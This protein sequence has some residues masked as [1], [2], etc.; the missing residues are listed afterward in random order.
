MNLA[1]AQYALKTRDCSLHEHAAASAY[2]HSYYTFERPDLLRPVRLTYDA[3]PRRIVRDDIEPTRRA[4]NPNESSKVGPRRIMRLD[5]P[6]SAYVITTTADGETWLCRASDIDGKLESGEGN[7]GTGIRLRAL[8][9]VARREI[10]ADAARSRRMLASINA[11][12]RAFWAKESAH[13]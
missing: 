13:G 5:G 12:N 11:A 8:D 9:A 2:L 3:A 1:D 6:A 4:E 7:T 10:E